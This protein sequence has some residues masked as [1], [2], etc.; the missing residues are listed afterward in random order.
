M[1]QLLFLTTVAFFCLTSCKKEETACYIFTI[2]TFADVE[3]DNFNEYPQTKSHDEEECGLTE[4]EAKEINS[5]LFFSDVDTI[6]GF[7]L[8]SYSTCTYRKK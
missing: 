1:K 7:I 8:T 4:E 5:S 3:P 2:T 6:S